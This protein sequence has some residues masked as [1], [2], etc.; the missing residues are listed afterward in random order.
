MSSFLNNANLTRGLRNNNPGNLV[1]T[2]DN[3]VG[4]IPHSQSKDG[5]FEQFKD[6]KYGVRAMLRDVVNDIIKG[7]DTIR[8]LITEFAPPH[9]NNTLSYINDVSKKVGIAPDDKI[10]VIHSKLLMLLARA[11]ITKENGKD[12]KLVTDSHIKAGISIL[13]KF[14][15]TKVAVKTETFKIEYLIPLM[16]FFYTVFAGT[17]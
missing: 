9:E 1:R 11:I 3:W 12:G 2:A 13:G 6:I 4:K 14:S 8:K 5:R 16:L 7:K 17:L 10:T 15:S